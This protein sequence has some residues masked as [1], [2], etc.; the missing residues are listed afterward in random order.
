MGVPPRSRGSALVRARSSFAA[1]R[2]LLPVQK[3]VHTETTGGIVLLAAAVASLVW[4]N[5]RWSPSY[6]ALWGVEASLHIGRFALA[7]TLR[8][9]IND[10]LMVVF[11]FVV[12]LEVK[13]EFVHGEATFR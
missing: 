12:G 10:A 7:P 8:D 2:F 13:R 4:A 5:S 6:E 9:W 3:F 1:R 11:F